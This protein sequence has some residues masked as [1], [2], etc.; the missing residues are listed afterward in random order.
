MSKNNSPRDKRYSQIPG[1]TRMV[2]SRAQADV[3]GRVWPRGAVYQ[4]LS[5]GYNNVRGC[6]VSVIT[7]RGERVEVPS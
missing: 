3:T 7:I 6:A 4:P 2:M 5:G 1:D